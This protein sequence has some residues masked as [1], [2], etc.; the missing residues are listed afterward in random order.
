MRI[1][2]SYSVNNIALAHEFVMVKII[3]VQR[4]G[5]KVGMIRSAAQRE[6]EPA[7]G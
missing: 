2:S 1:F 5:S 3:E 4:A 7:G 6:I